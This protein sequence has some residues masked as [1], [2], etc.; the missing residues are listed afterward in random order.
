MHRDPDGSEL[1]EFKER[2]LDKKEWGQFDHIVIWSKI[3][4]IKVEIYSYSMNAQIV[5]GDEFMLDKEVIILLYCNQN[6]WGDVEN[7]YDLMHPI[8]Q[9]ICKG[10]TY[11]RRSDEEQQIY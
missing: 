10:K 8:P 3:Y 9:Q 4:H 11:E 5:D 7:H 2:G 6:N 1:N